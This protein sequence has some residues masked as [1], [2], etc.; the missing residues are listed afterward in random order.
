VVHPLSA[1]LVVA[2]LG[3]AT[4]FLVLAVRGHLGGPSSSSRVALTTPAPSSTSQAPSAQPSGTQTTSGRLQ[5]NVVIAL[6]SDS[7]NRVTIDAGTQVQATV[8]Q[9][10]GQWLVVSL[11]AGTTPAATAQGGD[12][13]KQASGSAATATTFTVVTASG[14]MSVTVPQDSAVTI[15]NA[16]F[17]VQITGHTP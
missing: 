11:V 4:A 10:N 16:P 3:L 5:D 7:V 1:A 8:T 13:T 6:S 2:A 12:K 17:G 9:Q 15:S 14:P